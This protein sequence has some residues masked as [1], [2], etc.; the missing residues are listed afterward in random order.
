MDG[1]PSQSLNN[2]FHQ[3]ESL[4]LKEKKASVS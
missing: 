2:S 3:K 1:S 4:I